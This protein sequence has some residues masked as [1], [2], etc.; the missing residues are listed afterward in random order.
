VTKK[1]D[2]ERRRFDSSSSSKSR[3]AKQIVAKSKAVS[4]RSSHSD[5]EN[6]GAFGEDGGREG[7]GREWIRGDETARNEQLVRKSDDAEDEF[8]ERF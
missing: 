8:S 7:G 3:K 1:D 4:F 5:H 6:G 2:E